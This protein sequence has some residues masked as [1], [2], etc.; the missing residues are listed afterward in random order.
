MLA[1]GSKMSDVLRRQR[2]SANSPIT[3]FRFFKDHHGLVTQPFT[4]NG[5]KRIRDLRDHLSL[6]RIGKDPFDHFNIGK[7]HSYSPFQIYCLGE[8]NGLASAERTACGGYTPPRTELRPS[9]NQF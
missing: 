6:L 9:S 8:S 7:W 2:L 4:L 5:D 1:T 3:T